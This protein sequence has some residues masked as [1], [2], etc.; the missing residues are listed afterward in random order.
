[1]LFQTDFLV[2]TTKWRGRECTPLEADWRKARLGLMMMMMTMI[3]KIPFFKTQG[4]V[5]C[6]SL[7]LVIH[8]VEEQGTYLKMHTIEIEIISRTFVFR[9]KSID[10]C[11]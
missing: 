3:T 8:F 4:N 10:K 11:S 1:M 5:V 7:S 6:I 2:V 9:D